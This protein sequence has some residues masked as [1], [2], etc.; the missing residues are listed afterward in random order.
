MDRIGQQPV[1]LVGVSGSA[2]SLAAL[3]WAAQEARRRDAKLRVIQ[4][5]QPHPARAPYAG[6][7]CAGRS[8]LPSEA[9]AADRL[10]A[11]VRR[12]LG[13]A[14]GVVMSI[15]L[16]EGFAERILAAESARADLLVLGSGGQSPV[17]QSDP[18]IVDRPIGPVVRACLCHA[19]CPVV[20]IS[21]AMAAELGLHEPAMAGHAS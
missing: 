16:I 2:A 10:V 1:I 18:L 12:M 15:D 3:C 21:P 9:A 7:G 8:A 11:E 19:R 4:A 17:A 5:W 14:T 13:T 20:I 6:T